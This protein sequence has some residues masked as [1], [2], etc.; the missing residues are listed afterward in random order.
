MFNPDISDHLV[1]EHGTDPYMLQLDIKAIRRL[2]FYEDIAD[3]V[4]DNLKMQL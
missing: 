2:S 3:M 1:M 4:A